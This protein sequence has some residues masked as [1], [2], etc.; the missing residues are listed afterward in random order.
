MTLLNSDMS[1]C[2]I[3]YNLHDRHIILRLV[4]VRGKVQGKPLKYK[5]TN[6]NVRE[7]IFPPLGKENKN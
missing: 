2:D 4:T 3:L 5:M 1:R 7:R 6:R